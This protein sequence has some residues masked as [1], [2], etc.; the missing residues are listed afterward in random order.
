M[1]TRIDLRQTHVKVERLSRAYRERVASI[2]GRPLMA[3]VYFNLVRRNEVI[4]DGEGMDVADV[5]QVTLDVIETL[6]E[7]QDADPAQRTDWSDWSVNITDEAGTVVR[8]I[9]L[10]TTRH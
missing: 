6:R 3:R 2:P 9:P 8:T 4:L 10:R 5:D 7:L 1:A